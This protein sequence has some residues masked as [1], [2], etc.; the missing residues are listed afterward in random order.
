MANDISKP[1]IPLVLPETC[2]KDNPTEKMVSSAYKV[3]SNVLRQRN[4]T[5]LANEVAVFSTKR[6]DRRSRIGLIESATLFQD[7]QMVGL[8][9]LSNPVRLTVLAA[10]SEDYTTAPQH[11]QY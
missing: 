2:P 9:R 1:V 4:D 7:A 5:S 11:L 3:S 6:W 10:K 8:Y